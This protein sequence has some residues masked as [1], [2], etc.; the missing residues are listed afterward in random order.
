MRRFDKTKNIK[1]ANLLAE[2]RYLASKGL[3][4]EYFEESNKWSADPIETELNC[5]NQ[6]IKLT[7]KINDEVIDVSIDFYVTKEGEYRPATWGYHGGSPEEFPEPIL[8][9]KEISSNY[10]L[11]EEDKQDIIDSQ[12]ELILD[13]YLEKCKPTND[14]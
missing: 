6:N 10:A 1:K 14:Y 4:K 13:K 11:T 12:Q 9:V 8:N 7:F 2:N 3:I 5:D